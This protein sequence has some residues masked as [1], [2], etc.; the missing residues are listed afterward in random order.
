MNLFESNSDPRNSQTARDHPLDVAKCNLKL[1]FSGL[2]A[3][4][5]WMTRHHDESLSHDNDSSSLDCCEAGFSNIRQNIENEILNEDFVN[6]EMT[7]NGSRKHRLISQNSSKSGRK[8]RSRS[9]SLSMVQW[10][11]KLA[12]QDIVVK[13]KNTQRLDIFQKITK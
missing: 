10:E 5:S 3:S 2:A 12:E 9:N 13:P 8:Y 1:P 4:S 11:S 7:L 6:N